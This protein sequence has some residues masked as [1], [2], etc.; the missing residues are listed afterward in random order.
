LPEPAAAA[1]EFVW[2]T[3]PSLPGLS[4]R[5]TTLTFAGTTCV[6]VAAESA[7]CFTGAL[8]VT[9]CD[10]PDPAVGEGSGWMPAV[11]DCELCW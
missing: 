3:G 8:C 11:W 4:T 6:D 1:E 2:V 9:A 7:V 10:C 5:I